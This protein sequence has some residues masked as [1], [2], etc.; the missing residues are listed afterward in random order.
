MNAST[1][2]AKTKGFTLAEIMIAST[3]GLVVLAAIAQTFVVTFRIIHK[4]Q[5]IAIEIGM[6]EEYE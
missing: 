6:H 5:V 1:L 4:N 3:I 2:R